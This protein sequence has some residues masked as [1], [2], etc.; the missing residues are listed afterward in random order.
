MLGRK[1][2]VGSRDS[3]LQH[4]WYLLAAAESKLR[5]GSVRGGAVAAWL[6]VLA[7][8]PG[9]G[10]GRV[11]QVKP[12]GR[13]AARVGP[14]GPGAQDWDTEARGGVAEL[15]LIGRRYSRG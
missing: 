7:G 13:R 11:R 8:S 6:L 4:Y 9:V 1:E 2:G 3:P 14:Q 12:R 5:V 15:S 10:R